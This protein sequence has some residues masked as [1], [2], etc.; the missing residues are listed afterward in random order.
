MY[1]FHVLV[2]PLDMHTAF[3][4]EEHFFAQPPQL[5]L[6]Y[7]MGLTA[8][9]FIFIGSFS[10]RLGAPPSII[11][12]HL[13]VARF[14]Q[15]RV[16]LLGRNDLGAAMHQCHR[17]TLY[18]FCNFYWPLPCWAPPASG[19][20]A[21]LSEPP[22]TSDSYTETVAMSLLILRLQPSGPSLVQ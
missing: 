2:M 18:P 8:S 7:N 13:L 4:S 9:Y 3:L 19:G 16:H 20:T 11:S 21:A 10:C 15:H 22:V 14:M 5:H 6:V 17:I 1:T 12:P